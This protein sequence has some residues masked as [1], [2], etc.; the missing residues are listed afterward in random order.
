MKKNAAIAPT[1]GRIASSPPTARVGTLAPKAAEMPIGAELSA[2]A[3][4]RASAPIAGRKMTSKG[5][6]RPRSSSFQG[7]DR[8][9]SVW[10][11]SG[12]LDSAVIPLAWTRQ[13]RGATQARIAPGGRRRP[14]GL[15]AGRP[16]RV[17]LGQLADD[18]S[19]LPGGSREVAEEIAA[20]FTHSAR[21]SGVSADEVTNES[22]ARGT[23]R[24]HPRYCS[25]SLRPRRRPSLQP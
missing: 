20:E 12:E 17:P 2:N 15:S 10:G 11:G 18:A 1:G 22:L 8:W 4:I 19:A 13:P 7:S 5:R 24:S 9:G 23:K 14:R 25:R 16:C 3:V 6:I 21:S